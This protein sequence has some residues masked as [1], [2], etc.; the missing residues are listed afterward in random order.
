[1]QPPISDLSRQLL[2]TMAA[3]DYAKTDF[4]TNFKFCRAV[5]EFLAVLLEEHLRCALCG[6]LDII[7][8]HLTSAIS[9]NLYW[10]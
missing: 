5:L 4:D 8:F 3:E 7:F 1:M 10:I 9:E 2:S 6:R